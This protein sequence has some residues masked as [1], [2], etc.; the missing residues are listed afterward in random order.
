SVMSETPMIEKVRELAVI[1]GKEIAS[2]YRGNVW[3]VTSKADESPIT[4]ADLRANELIVAGL[5]KFSNDPIVSEEGDVL[6]KAPSSRFW[7]V[8]P[9]DGTRDFVNRMDTFV[10]CIALIENGEPILGVIYAPISEELYSA[11]KG[12]G[13]IGPEGKLIF[14]RNTRTELAAAGS[15]ST[16]SDRMK[17]LYEQFGITSI[18]R[19]G[20]ALKFCKVASGDFDVYPRFGPTKEWDTAAG[21]IIAEEAGC[22]VVDMSTGERLLYGKPNLDNRGFVCCRNDLDVAE[23]IYRFNVERLKNQP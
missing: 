14:N 2:I 19:F 9:L 12:K 5:K 11:E 21:Q 1:A 18:E 8:D 10:V 6:L 4:Q 17:A 3:T 16:P 23:Q 13:A 15:R 22:K 7:L 20:S